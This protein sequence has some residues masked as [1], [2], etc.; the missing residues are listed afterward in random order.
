LP[1]LAVEAAGGQKVSAAGWF[2][3]SVNVAS[4]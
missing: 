4:G 2:R 1:A 3:F